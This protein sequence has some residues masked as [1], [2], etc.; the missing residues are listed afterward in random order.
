MT[1]L[2]ITFEHHQH[3]GYGETFTVRCDQLP[4][5]HE[6]RIVEQPRVPGPGVWFL[7]TATRHAYSR[8]RGLTRK[9]RE[10]K[11]LDAAKAAAVAYVKAKVAEAK[12]QEP[13]RYGHG[14]YWQGG[15]AWWVQYL[16]PKGEQFG[17]E[18][19]KAVASK[20]SAKQWL[21]H[22]HEYIAAKLR[23]LNVE[24]NVTEGA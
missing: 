8:R 3:N 20:K 18:T 17:S 1:D 5:K 4:V 10:F 14:Q 15:G 9:H 21:D 19:P 24:A 22:P 2:N 16:T 6:C 13:V 11:S 23:E 12:R 7:C